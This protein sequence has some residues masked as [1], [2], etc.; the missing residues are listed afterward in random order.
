MVTLRFIQKKRKRFFS[1]LELLLGF[2]HFIVSVCFSSSMCGQIIDCR[3]HTKN[4]DKSKDA[5]CLY[6]LC[7]LNFVCVSAYVVY[8]CVDRAQAALWHDSRDIHGIMVNLWTCII[9]CLSI[10]SIHYYYYLWI[11]F[12]RFLSIF[13]L[14]LLLFV[15]FSVIFSPTTRFFNSF[16]VSVLSMVLLN[17]LLLSYSDF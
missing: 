13:R 3:T 5:F 11:I 16:S 12:I 7:R 9:M 6:Q 8:V 14:F 10:M 1:L 17:S 4:C 15:W 2:Y